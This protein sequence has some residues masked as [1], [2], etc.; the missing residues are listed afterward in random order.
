MEDLMNNNLTEN[1]VEAVLN[2]TVLKEDNSS[3]QPPNEE[4]RK[5]LGSLVLSLA[6]RLETMMAGKETEWKIHYV[7]SSEEKFESHIKREMEGDY[8]LGQEVLVTQDNLCEDE[9]YGK[10][11]YGERIKE[12]KKIILAKEKEKRKNEFMP[13]AH[14]T[15]TSPDCLDSVGNVN[16]FIDG[17]VF[18]KAIRGGTISQEDLLQHIVDKL[19]K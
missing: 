16:L 3:G 7:G 18:S 17:T 4:E 8:G 10:L 13:K 11:P 12:A 1:Q 2:H 14:I 9:D 19:K 6:S 15:I 5:T